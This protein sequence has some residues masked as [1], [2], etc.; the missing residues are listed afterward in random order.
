MRRDRETNA[1]MKRKPKRKIPL[2]EVTLLL[3]A[4][5]TLL[6]ELR[7]YIAHWFT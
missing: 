3:G 1:P 4:L 6:H 5:G 2:H 7:P